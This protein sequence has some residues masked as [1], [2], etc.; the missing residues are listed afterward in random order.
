MQLPKFLWRRS[1]VSKRKNFSFSSSGMSMTGSEDVSSSKTG[2]SGDLVVPDDSCGMSR[3]DFVEEKETISEVDGSKIPTGIAVAYRERKPSSSSNPVNWKLMHTAVP[4]TLFDARVKRS[5]EPVEV[6]EAFGVKK[7]TVEKNWHLPKNEN[8]RPRQ[9]SPKSETQWRN[10]FFS[11]P[12]NPKEVTASL[13]LWRSSEPGPFG[14]EFREEAQ[15]SLHI[16]GDYDLEKGGSFVA[17][18]SVE[19]L[20]KGEVC[21]ELGIGVGRKVQLYSN[22]EVFLDEKYHGTAVGFGSKNVVKIVLER[23]CSMPVEYCSRVTSESEK[24]VDETFDT[25]KETLIPSNLQLSVLKDNN[26]YY[27]MFI[28]RA[29]ANLVHVEM[30]VFYPSACIVGLST[31]VEDVPEDEPCALPTLC[32]VQSSDVM[33][34]SIISPVIAI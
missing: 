33:G 27:T 4:A 30:C 22:G 19:K 26:N 17:E 3:R 13:L 5:V 34:S 20:H 10:T 15:E 18:A 8:R 12:V 6:S 14:S 29:T 9:R 25:S 11:K 24:S 21:L 23:D 31:A 2:S 16:D 32:A 28:P 7:S 1:L